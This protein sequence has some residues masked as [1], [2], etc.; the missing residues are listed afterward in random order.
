MNTTNSLELVKNAVSVKNARL[1][2]DDKFYYVIH[3]DTMILKMDIMTREISILLPVSLSSQNAIEQALTYINHKH[4]N[5]DLALVEKLNGI[6]KSELWK[7]WK[8]KRYE[9]PKRRK[10]SDII[11]MAKILVSGGGA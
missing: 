2:K 8:Y 3:Y 7:M 4:T 10:N 11:E 1:F 9:Q 5:I 6:T